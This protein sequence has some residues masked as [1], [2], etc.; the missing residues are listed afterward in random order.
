VPD[1]AWGHDRIVLAQTVALEEEVE[2]PIEA[3]A[4]T[5]KSRPS[6]TSRP[7]HRS[8]HL[9]K[10]DSVDLSRRAQ[11][12]P[13][14]PPAWGRPFPRP[15]SHV[16]YILLVSQRAILLPC[17]LSQPATL[18]HTRRHSGLASLVGSPCLR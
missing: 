5:V 16:P 6:L 11:A 18:A 7:H 14:T 12:L 3:P 8:P 13:S 2:T 15:H 1:K 10:F 17:T 4:A 9:P